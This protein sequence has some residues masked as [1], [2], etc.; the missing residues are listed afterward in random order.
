M[1]KVKV[2]MSTPSRHWK[3]LYI[4]TMVFLPLST[5]APSRTL[6]KAWLVLYGTARPTVRL[7]LDLLKEG[8][9]SNVLHCSIQPGR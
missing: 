2:L 5:M 1:M 3:T 8:V 7:R 9:Q 4:P 6:F